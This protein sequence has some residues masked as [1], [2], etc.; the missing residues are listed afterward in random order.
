MNRTVTMAVLVVVFGIE[1][2]A[3]E[4]RLPPQAP[5]G[6]GLA[7]ATSAGSIDI[8]HYETSKRVRE[9]ITET[10]EETTADG[11]RV[12]KDG[13]PILKKVQKEVMKLVPE[14]GHTIWGAEDFRVFRDGV[15]LDAEMLAELLKQP[16]PVVVYR[17]SR[18]LDPF[19]LQF[20]KAGTLVVY[21]RPGSGQCVPLGPLKFPPPTPGSNAPSPAPR[22]PKEPPPAL[23]PAPPPTAG[24]AT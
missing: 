24:K 8:M 4:T 16:T 18:L 17:S 14:E 23:R 6:F 13:K 2:E 20:F 5:P 3:A 19:Y 1:S 10:V 15:R 22:P 11:K 21:V 9:T 7:T 12:L